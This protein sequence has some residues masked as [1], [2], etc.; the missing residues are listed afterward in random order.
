MSSMCANTVFKVLLEMVFLQGYGKSLWLMQG[1]FRSNGGC[2][3]VKKPNFLLTGS[4]KIF[5]PKAKL[6]VKKKLT[7]NDYS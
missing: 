4:E 5:N 2:G 1:F 3:Y 7:V 6:P